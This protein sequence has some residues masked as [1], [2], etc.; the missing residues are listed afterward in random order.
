MP[1]KHFKVNNKDTKKYVRFVQ[2]CG[3][4]IVNF[5]SNFVTRSD[6]AHY[7]PATSFWCFYC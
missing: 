3:V 1:L 5:N 7:Y 2:S 4:S 6:R